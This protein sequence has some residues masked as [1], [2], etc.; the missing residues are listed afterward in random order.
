MAAE[1][2]QVSGEESQLGKFLAD[3]ERKSLL[4]FM[5][6]GSVD[7]GKSTLIGRLLY[8]GKLVFSDQVSALVSD[9]RKRGRSDDEIDYSLLV[10]GLEAEREQGITI[11][12]AY[13]FFATP[14]RRFIVADTPG[15]EQYTRNMATG[16]STADLA[17]VVVDASSG[18]K[19]QTRRHTFIASL[20]GVRHVVLAV[21]KI[22]LLGFD[23][24]AFRRIAE[25]YA[26]FSAGLGFHSIVSIPIS[27]RFGHNVTSRSA[28]MS[29]YEG[30]AL[31]EHLES[32][33]VEDAGEEGSFRFPV[34]Y[35]MRPGADFRGFAG[36][37]SSGSIDVGDEVVATKSGRR[38]NVRR[39]VTSDGDLQRARAGQAIAVTLAN[40]IELSRGDMLAEP[41]RPP[42]VADQFAADVIWFDE[43]QLLP[44][45]TYILRT[46]ND[47]VNAFVSELKYR[48]D[49]DTFAHDAAKSLNINEIGNCNLSTQHPIVFDS[50]KD[51]QTS[52]GFVLVERQS[53]R[54]VAAGLIRHSLRRAENIHWQTLDVDLESRANMKRQKPV[55]LWFTGLSGSGK[56]TIANL[57]E[58]KLHDAGKHTYLLEGDNVRHGLNRDLGFTEVDRVENI[59]RVAEVARLMIDAGLIVMVSF[60][61]PF[62]AERQ[63]ARELMGEGRFVEIFVDTPFEECVRRDPKGLYVKALRGEIK[64][65]TGIDSPYE[66]P[67]EP[68]I[69]LSTL[70]RSPEQMIEIIESWLAKSG[71]TD[72]GHIVG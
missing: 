46:E 58:K 16:A 71:F 10:D 4:R 41:G 31:L 52:G 50:Y 9:S 26:A 11:D 27:A 37:V 7:D 54:T 45:R 44:G 42:H 65:F 20:F 66:A 51:N 67:D 35:V 23:Q 30:L 1:K 3:Q 40:D 25:E 36:T 60:I 32:V 70:G 17:V 38:A 22:D 43:H 6:C 21:N 63:M 64:N 53:N 68:E 57:L 19:R 69:H 18:I 61:S 15:H 12:V 72:T 47:Q 29:W 59:R 48:I 24:D 5:M 49:V 33:A 62:K 2:T 34:Q 14:K 39:I 13:R 28:E 55:V 8:D 56:S